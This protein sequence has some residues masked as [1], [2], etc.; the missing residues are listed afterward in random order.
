M[1]RTTAEANDGNRYTEG[2]P[3]LGVPATVVGA[4]EMN[5]IQEEIV[6]V[7]L[8]AGITLNGSDEDQL[9]EALGVFF[10][11]GGTT[12]STA[13]I[14]NN[15]TDQDVTGLSFDET[16]TKGAVFTYDIQRSTDTVNAGETG[17]AFVRY[18]P[19]ADDWEIEAQALSDSGVTLSIGSD[20][21]VKYTSDNMA[22][23]SY[24]GTMRFSGIVKLAQ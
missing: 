12:Q 10:A 13:T 5:N 4:E 20:G 15:Q 24:A 8:A 14:A 22:G 7:V 2:N 1:K 23:S 19:V 16:A 3:T 6:N 18:D 9:L 17:K 21:Q 11:R